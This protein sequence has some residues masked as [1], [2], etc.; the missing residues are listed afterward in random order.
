M[1]DIIKRKLECSEEEAEEIVKDLED[2]SP[3]FLDILESWCKDKPYSDIKIGGYTVQSLMN[4]YDLGFIGALLTLDWVYK[5][6]DEASKALQFGI[7]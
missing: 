4:D 2:I 7:R 3:L 5:K 1:K 6:P